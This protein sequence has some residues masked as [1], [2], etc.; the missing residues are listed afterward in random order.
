MSTASP[1][2]S[3]TPVRL[4]EIATQWSLLRLA[5]Q[6]TVTSA[7]PARNALVLRYARAIRGYVGALIRHQ[8]DADEVAQE[9]LMRLLRG[10][11]A[12]ATKERGRFR[13]LLHVAV[14]NQVRTFWSKQNRR[15][16]VN[17]EVDQLPDG[18][19]AAEARE[20]AAWRQSIL[21][22]AWG[23]LEEYERM[24]PGS[25]AYRVLRMRTDFPDA[26]S[27]WLAARLSKET[28]RPFRADAMRQQLRR[29]RVR[30]A[31]CLVDEISR[32]L[33]EATPE[34]IEEELI[35]LGLREY[36]RELIPE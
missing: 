7:G 34:R 6:N 35:A 21:K 2:L 1:P 3:D 19:E 13:D 5:H 18:E 31:L 30:F 12:G 15:R 26:D 10:D 8:H 28:G 29:A 32:T 9:V 33:D 16:P 17:V 25:V 11:F 14:R 22:M 4:D 20:L 24:H 36:V 23:G 27:V